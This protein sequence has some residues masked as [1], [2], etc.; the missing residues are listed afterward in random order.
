M[1]CERIGKL[2]ARTL[3]LPVTEKSIVMT[4]SFTSM[5]LALQYVAARFAG[6]ATFVEA[7]H[8]L[9]SALSALLPIMGS[10]SSSLLRPLLPMP[11]FGQ[12][13]LYQSRGKQRSRS[14]NRLPPTRSSF[15][16]SNSG[17][18]QCLS[19]LRMCSSELASLRRATVRRVRS[20]GDETTGWAHPRNRQ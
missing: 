12:G 6:Q 1:R 9:P 11:L 10:V 2:S 16:R 18:D 3:Q 8:M 17:M 4:S 7:L 19:C 20:P 15:T 5:L 14:W 13:A